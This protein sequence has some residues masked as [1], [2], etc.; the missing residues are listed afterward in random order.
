MNK[1][2]L[3]VALD[4]KSNKENLA[5]A[6]NLSSVTGHYGFKIN[7]NSLA[8]L[9][10]PKASD[11]I[12]NYELVKGV[13]ALGRPVF[14]D[15]KMWNGGGTM[16][17]LAEQYSKAGVTYINMYPQAPLSH[18]KQVKKALGDNTKLLTMTVYTRLTEEECKAEFGRGIDEQIIY[19][20]KKAE[21]AG[22][23]GMILPGRGL[24]LDYIRKSNLLKV[25]PAVRPKWYSGQEDDG[26]VQVS[27]L[28]QVVKNGCNAIVCGTPIRN[29]P[30]GITQ[31]EALEM[32]LEEIVKI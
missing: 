10:N 11:D 30:E 9:V 28:E 2:V 13:I 20:A 21:K 12:T 6:E 19:S 26:Q 8:R 29:P 31:C 15:F 18:I 27:S 24:V 22:A 16:S 4:Y 1:P 23:D 32:T 7:L 17:D 3:L 25:N 14:A 5:F